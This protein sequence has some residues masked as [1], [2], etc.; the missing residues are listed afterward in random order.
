MD[1]LY[2]ALQRAI[3][4]ASNGE[5]REAQAVLE[6][7]DE[8]L[9]TQFHDF[10]ALQKRRECD[11]ADAMA[12]ARHD[13]GNALS[14]AQSS[15]EAMIDSVVHI[16]DRRLTRIRDILAAVNDSMYRLT[17]DRAGAGVSLGGRPRER[18]GAEDPIEAE[19]NSLAALAQTKDVVLAYEAKNATRTLRAFRANSDRESATRTLRRALLITVRC[20]PQG[21]V[22]GVSCSRN[23]DL[24]LQVDSPDLAINLLEAFEGDAQFLERSGTVLISL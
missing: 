21:S 10:L 2:Q 5:I 1:P 22:V 18:T 19:I 4:L 24:A 13:M 12:A 9:A 14:I 20:A 16:S 6:T 8:P 15:V 3:E 23:G 17:T 11:R 7:L